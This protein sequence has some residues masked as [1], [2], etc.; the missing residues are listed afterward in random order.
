MVLSLL[1]VTFVFDF[2]DTLLKG[3]AHYERYGMEYLV[4]TPILIGLCIAAMFVGKR[5]F[6]AAFVIGILVY[7]ASWILRQF[8]TLT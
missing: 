3:V 5:K 7:E 8:R 2:L 1:G 4:R 6:H